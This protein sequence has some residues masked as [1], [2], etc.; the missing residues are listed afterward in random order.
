M[1]SARYKIFSSETADKITAFSN[2]NLAREGRRLRPTLF[3]LIVN[4]ALN[5]AK[6]HYTD[7]ALLVN[8]YF[9]KS[10]QRV[11]SITIILSAS[12]KYQAREQLNFAGLI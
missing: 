4:S 3:V 1:S 6:R 10:H 9:Q 7:F 8:Y 5:Q 11:V 12:F 2:L